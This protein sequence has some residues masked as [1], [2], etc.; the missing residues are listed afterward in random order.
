[1]SSD[2]GSSR[3]DSEKYFVTRPRSRKRQRRTSNGS[4]EASITI[5][6]ERGS[7]TLEQRV[8]S[9]GGRP[10]DLEVPNAQIEILNRMFTN[11]MVNISS[12]LNSLKDTLKGVFEEV[13]FLKYALHSRAGDP[14]P[15]SSMALVS[16]LVPP[17]EE[18]CVV[19][20]EVVANLDQVAPLAPP[21]EEEPSTPVLQE[22]PTETPEEPVP[23]L[24]EATEEV[25]V[26]AIAAATAA[27]SVADA[28]A[29]P[30][31]SRS[32]RKQRTIG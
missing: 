14:V 16:P 18:D 1:M 15:D 29:S 20:L 23:A 28:I 22:Q 12:E 30:V 24:E 7:Y 13:K 9:V 25:Q 19:E 3:S 17:V 27:A 10:R 2:E 4:T 8:R 26:S 21:A 5:V 31:A 32:V 6:Q 11:Q